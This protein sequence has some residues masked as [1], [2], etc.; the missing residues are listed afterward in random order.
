MAPSLLEAV[1]RAV[2]DAT[3]LDEATV[4]RCTV[5]ERLVL[6]EVS[7][8][9][10]ERSAGVA[11]RPPG[12]LSVDPGG[13]AAGEVAAWVTRDHEEA[14]LRRAVGLAT[15]NALSA[16]VIYWRH[17]DP[18]EALAADVTA[19]TTV[20]LFRPAFRKFGEVDVRVIEREPVE[21]P[22]TPDGV[23]VSVFPP[24]DAEEA[25]AGADVVFITGSTLLYGGTE[26]YL[27]TA[28]GVPDVVLIGASAS[29]VPAPAFDAGSTMLAGAAVTD[30]ETV[31]AGALG[32]ECATDLH[33]AGLA[34]VYVQAGPASGLD[35]G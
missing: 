22:T 33:G 35:F 19:I 3:P 2:G 27:R 7:A 32:G 28:R 23:T 14:L 25:M 21:P 6:L 1:R 9:R 20:G 8:P 29:F 5:G 10:G 18:F 15:L 34:K 12:E 16:P 4:D 13:E 30:L 31:R 17:G 11:H 24:K 26:R